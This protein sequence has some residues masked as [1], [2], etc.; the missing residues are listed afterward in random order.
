MFRWLKELIEEI[1][2]WKAQRQ[3]DKIEMLKLRDEIDTQRTSLTIQQLS[4]RASIINAKGDIL[5]IKTGGTTNE[6][7]RGS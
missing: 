6:L 2:Y 3:R 4:S 7:V 1:Q 5:Q